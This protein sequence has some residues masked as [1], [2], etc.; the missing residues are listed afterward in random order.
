[1]IFENGHTIKRVKTYHGSDL[2]VSQFGQIIKVI[3]CSSKTNLSDAYV[4]NLIHQIESNGL[5]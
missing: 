4:S 2:C 1:M 3:P 5:T